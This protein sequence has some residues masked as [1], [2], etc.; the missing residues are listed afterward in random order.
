MWPAIVITVGIAAPAAFPTDVDDARFGE[1]MSSYNKR[2]D[3]EQHRRAAQLLH[4]IAEAHPK[5]RT[6]QLWCA[7]TAYYCAHR[8][9]D[10][11]D[12]MLPIAQWGATCGERLASTYPGDYDAELWRVLTRFK[13]IAAESVIPPLGEIEDKAKELERLIEQK[14]DRHDAYM[15][16]G[17]LYRELPGWPISI[18]DEDRA[19]R[20]HSKGA[21]VSGGDTE[22]LLQLADTWNARGSTGDARRA[23]RRCIDEGTGPADLTWEIADAKDWARK[24][25]AELD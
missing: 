22:M 14:P 20:I 4:T 1:A 7:R 9:R 19:L 10:D 5:D 21:R 8:Y 18:G 11:K 16:L 17:T 13:L 23:Y 24:Q 15:L 25:L 2:S 12:A 3:R 6:A